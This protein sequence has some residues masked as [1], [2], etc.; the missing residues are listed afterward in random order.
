MAGRVFLIVV[1]VVTAP[2]SPKTTFSTVFPFLWSIVCLYMGEVDR[3]SMLLWTW[4][5]VCIVHLY[6]Y[7]V[8]ACI[9]QT[10]NGE[11]SRSEVEDSEG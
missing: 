10:M 4:I 9:L 3:S 8:R 5:C 6:V 1:F 11:G 7:C 2:Y